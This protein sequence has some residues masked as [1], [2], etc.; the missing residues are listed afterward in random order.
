MI[1]RYFGSDPLF[2]D[3]DALDC[4]CSPVGRKWNVY[5]GIQDVNEPR[6]DLQI[7]PVRICS[8][9]EMLKLR[10]NGYYVSGT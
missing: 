9:A 5:A 7:P 2:R 6:F 10:S 3:Q 8:V 4:I 1:E